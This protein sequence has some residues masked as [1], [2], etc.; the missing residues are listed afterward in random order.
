MLPWSFPGRQVP[1]LTS[2]TS[3]FPLPVNPSPTDLNT[4]TSK[5]SSHI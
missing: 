1:A 3:D 4:G 2:H 5:E